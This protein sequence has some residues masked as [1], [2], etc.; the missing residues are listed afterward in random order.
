MSTKEHETFSPAKILIL[1]AGHFGRLAAG[2]LTKCFPHADFTVVDTREDRLNKVRKELGLKCFQEDSIAHLLAE[3]LS[4]ESWIV[5]AVPVHVAYQWLVS[6]LGEKRM[7]NRVPVPPA[8]DQQVPNPMRMP[9]GTLYTSYAT[10]I[11][12]DACNEPADICS[13]TRKPRQGNLFDHLAAIKVAD[14]QVAVVRSHQLA[15]GVGGYPFQALKNLLKQTAQSPG[16]YII[17]TACRCH[18]VVDCLSWK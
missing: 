7:V 16:C 5:P 15:P 11:C 13:H 6:H 17:A 10:W 8:V 4:A 18:G 14:V 3:R 1:G 12:P 2:R 9:S